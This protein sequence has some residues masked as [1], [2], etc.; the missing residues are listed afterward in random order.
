MVVDVEFE[1]VEV[2]VLLVP[3]VELVV[4]ALAGMV[5][6]AGGRVMG[7]DDAVAHWLM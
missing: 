3:L 6:V 7:L 2:M 5:I 4:E 1:E